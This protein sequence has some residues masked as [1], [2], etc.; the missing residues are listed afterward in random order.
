MKNRGSNNFVL[1]LKVWASWLEYVADIKEEVVNFS[2]SQFSK[3]N[4]LGFWF[5]NFHE[6]IDEAVNCSDENKSPMLK[7]FKL[8]FFKKN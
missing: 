7:G 1:A 4:Y 8:S 5:N 6:G 3:P 2:S